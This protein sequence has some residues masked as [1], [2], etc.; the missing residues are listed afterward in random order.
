[1]RSPSVGG[2]GPPGQQEPSVAGIPRAIPN[3][4]A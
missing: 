3:I 2:K 1:M 4:S